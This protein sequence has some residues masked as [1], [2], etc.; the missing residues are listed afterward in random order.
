MG[1]EDLVKSAAENGLGWSDYR[2]GQDQFKGKDF[3]TVEGLN[4]ERVTYLMRLAMVMRRVVHEKG[5]VDLLRHRV[6]TEL[7]YEPSSRTFA[8]F[9]AAI[10]RLG[11]QATPIQGMTYSS[12]SK[13]EDLVDTVR[14]FAGYSDAIVLRHPKVGA[15]EM[16]SRA[17]DDYSERR[18]PIINAGDGT[19][20]HPTQA[21]LDVFTVY[22]QFGRLDN[23][24]IVVAGDVLNGRTINSL[25]RVLAMYPGNRVVA[26]APEVLQM[27]PKRVD[28]LRSMGMEVNLTDEMTPE[29]VGWADVWYHTRIQKER[30]SAQAFVELKLLLVNGL[31]DFDDVDLERMN[32]N[33]DQLATEIGSE[34]Y[35]KVKS[36][37]V[38]TPELMS[39]AK[40]EMIL[41]HPFPRV[42]EIAKE[43]DRDPR[44]SYFQQAK[45]GMYVR[46]ALL[47]AMLADF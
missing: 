40:A 34:R 2:E 9:N 1:R 16:A 32:K 43:V 23:L 4:P 15:A 31:S 37:L 19:G 44:A 5:G 6:I 47:A 33:I 22:R 12:V 28:S 18:V 42:G 35:D 3:N 20:E 10:T 24:N 7:F 39:W 45:N 46:M 41:M 30:F 38:I 13:G 14:T 21:L 29:L 36:A 17:M 26:L 8:S 25:L 27:Q 11:A